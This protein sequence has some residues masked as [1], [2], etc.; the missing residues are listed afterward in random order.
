MPITKLGITIGTRLEMITYHDGGIIRVWTAIKDKSV[1]A[2][3]FVGTYLEIW[4][5]GRTLQ[6]GNDDEFEIRSCG[7]TCSRSWRKESCLESDDG[8]IYPYDQFNYTLVCDKCGR[9]C[10]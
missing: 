9:E 5:C 2:E 4:P 3:H 7:S 8:I 1:K 6:G 10:S